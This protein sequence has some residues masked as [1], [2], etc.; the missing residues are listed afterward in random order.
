MTGKLWGPVCVAPTALVFLLRSR[1]QFF[2]A[3][4]ESWPG[5]PMQCRNF[6]INRCNI[7]FPSDVSC[8]ADIHSH[9]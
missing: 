6:A 7:F 9:T 2:M 5:L 3:T 1:G 4:R 8:I